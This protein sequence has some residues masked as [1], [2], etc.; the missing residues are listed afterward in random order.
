M[1][2]GEGEYK[3]S[4]RHWTKSANKVRGLVKDMCTRALVEERSPVPVLILEIDMCDV[5]DHSETE[6]KTK[7]D[8]F[9]ETMEARKKF[10][11]TLQ[12]ED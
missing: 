7:L 4:A 5:R 1:Y 6:S 3:T 11:K 8:A 2:K 9:F 12:R 10:R